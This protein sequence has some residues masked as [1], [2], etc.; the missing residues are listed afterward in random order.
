MSEADT[1]EFERL[2]EGYHG[3]INSGHLTRASGVTSTIAAMPCFDENR[4]SALYPR[5]PYPI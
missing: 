5:D 3:L 2:M 4:A 1:K